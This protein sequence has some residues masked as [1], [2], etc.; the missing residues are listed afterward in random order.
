MP[1]LRRALGLAGSA[2][3]TAAGGVVTVQP[4]VIM[5]FDRIVPLTFR[6][7]RLILD[8]DAALRALSAAEPTSSDD[9]PTAWPSDAMLHSGVVRALEVALRGR[10]VETDSYPVRLTLD[11][12][13]AL[14]A[15]CR[16]LARGSRPEDRAA[17]RVAAAVVE[18]AF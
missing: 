12:A 8:R 4:P 3:A 7:I 6:A 2:G 16:E 13:K 11:D 9:A 10:L 18:A 17:L 5:S 15:W 1:L 14:V